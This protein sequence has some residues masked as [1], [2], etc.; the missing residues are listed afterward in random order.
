[1]AE[2]LRENRADAVEAGQEPD[3]TAA[4][5]CVLG[6]WRAYEDELLGFLVS[7]TRHRD[8]AEDLLQ[9]VFL[10]ALRAGE[11]FCELDNPRAWLFRVARNALVDRQRREKPGLSLP[12]DLPSPE[13]DDHPVDALSHCL[14]RNLRLMQERER[15]VIQACDLDGIRQSDY[16]KA[17]GITLNAA[18]SRLFRARR[19][20]RERLIANCDVRFDEDGRICCHTANAGY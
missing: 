4:F 6:A 7:R 18:K 17:S 11:G 2:R 20:L 15:D 10:K 5:D 1:M 9:D 3:D 13:P 14:A 12:E 16:A 19:Q 8:A